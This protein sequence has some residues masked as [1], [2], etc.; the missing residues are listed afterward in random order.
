MIYI[1]NKT[2]Y[3][4]NEL[5]KFKF[6]SWKDFYEMCISQCLNLEQKIMYHIEPMYM[7]EVQKILKLEH[8]EFDF[9]KI[10][11]VCYE[12][13]MDFLKARAFEEIWSLL[14]TKS[15]T[16]EVGGYALRYDSVNSYKIIENTQIFFNNIFAISRNP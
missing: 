3:I 8:D 7:K 11:Y 9:R 1:S 6:K 12:I 14:P 16:H 15:V 4:K 10:K 13:E 5:P 2:A